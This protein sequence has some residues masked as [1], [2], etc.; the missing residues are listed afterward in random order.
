[1][2]ITP[3][4]QVPRSAER[5]EGELLVKLRDRIQ[6]D[7]SLDFLKEDGYEVAEKFDFPEANFPGFGGDLVRI[8]V[9]EGLSTDEALAELN[10][11]PEVEFAEPDFLYELDNT[12]NKPDDLHW[13]LWGLDNSRDT[14]IDA[15]EAWAR[16]TGENGPVIAVLDTGVDY[17]H[18][19]LAANM[20]VNAGEIP[21][22]GIDNDGNGVVD[23]VHGFDAHNE[24][25]NPM[26]RDGHGTHCSG[27]IGA[28]GNNGEGVVGV[29]WNAKIMAVKIFNDD[30]EKPRAS[31]S[32]ILRGISYATNN[33]ARLT[34]NSWGGGWF[35]WSTKRAFKSS[36][37]LHV[38]AAGNDTE[39][40]DEDNHYPASY[41]IKN[42]L[43]VASVDRWEN[44]SSFSNYGDESV[45]LAAPGSSIYS[46]LPN[47]RY[48]YLSGTSMATPHV[49]GAAALLLSIDPDLTNDELLE[50]LTASV[51]PVEGLA[52]KVITGGRLNVGTAAERVA[53][54][55][56]S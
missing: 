11:D 28:V 52:D 24:N 42:K 13:G 19:D 12:Q 8:I 31:T 48:G 40:L 29:N 56:Q 32:A 1:M 36:P 16:S 20:W 9:P 43:V 4:V 55:G 50:D 10:K 23:D 7:A 6:D 27:T 46:T 14:D 54:R 21:G 44:I 34:S 49:T 47:G 22:D 37:A 15:P 38:M 17:N 53:T 35:S 51:D 33:G 39:D 41:D 18:P 25:G 26:D 45:H 3:R 5:V 30:A 2:Q